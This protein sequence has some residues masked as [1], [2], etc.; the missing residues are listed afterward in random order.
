MLRAS[1]RLSYA[2]RLARHRAKTTSDL[3]AFNFVRALVRATKRS[4]R[5]TESR[6][7]SVTAGS[8]ILRFFRVTARYRDRRA[9][10]IAS[11]WSHL[12]FPVLP[13]VVQSDSGATTARD[14]ILIGCSGDGRESQ[15]PERSRCNLR[16]KRR[17]GTTITDCIRSTGQRRWW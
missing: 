5:D 7:L 13:A 15:F 17:D 2:S 14:S 10:Q 6:A 1:S 8:R 4:P 9:Q 3:V 11:H 16:L 12:L